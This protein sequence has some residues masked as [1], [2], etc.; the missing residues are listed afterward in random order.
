MVLILQ[1]LIEIAYKEIFQLITI[2][3]EKL[4]LYEKLNY[5]FV[6]HRAAIQ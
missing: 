4:L 3:I 5:C 1:I 6:L 2:E